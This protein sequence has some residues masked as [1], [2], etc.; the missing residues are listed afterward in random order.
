MIGLAT[1]FSVVAG[2]WIAGGYEAR[3]FFRAFSSPSA[4]AKIGGLLVCF[5]VQSSVEEIFFRGWLL[6]ALA[7]K[8]NIVLSVVLTSAVFT[9]LHYGRHQPW[10]VT[11]VSFLFSLFACSWALKSGDIWGVMGW[12]SGWNW[13]LAVGFEVSITGLDARL[14]AL[15]VRLIPSGPAF[16]TGGADG[17]EGSFL[18]ALLL[19]A[20][21]VF[22]IWRG[23][24]NGQPSSPAYVTSGVAGS[25]GRAR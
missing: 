19:A 2:I 10:L 4:L 5:E 8:L 23:Q 6:S 9:F 13:L 16:L 1:S 12:H 24:S 21:S 14:P 11:L 15:L 7:R 22:L 20:G 18:S 17:P 25:S 3:G